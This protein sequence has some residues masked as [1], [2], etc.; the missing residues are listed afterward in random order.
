MGSLI[1]YSFNVILPMLIIGLYIKK[2]NREIIIKKYIKV[3]NFLILILVIMAILDKISYYEI[4]IKYWEKADES[5]LSALYNHRYLG[6]YRFYSFMGHPLYNAQLFLMFFV[7]NTCYNKYFKEILSSSKILVI[8]AL[9][10]ALTASKTGL[11]LLLVGIIFLVPKKNKFKY[12]LSLI[13]LGI[14]ILLS[15]VFN[16]TIER[17]LTTSLT[18]GRADIWELYKSMDIYPIKFL[19]GYGIDIITRIDEIILWG[20]AAFEYPIRGFAIQ[21]GV[22]FTIITYL[23]IG[24]YPVLCFIKNKNIYI[25]FGFLIIFLDVNTYNT[26]IHGRDYMI[27]YGLFVA[28]MNNISIH[29]REAIIN[30]EEK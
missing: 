23:I 6:Q 30:L 20:G 2:E 13:F 10:I 14:I 16:D 8:S 25:L 24:V 27:I 1:Y 28:I 12:Y 22:L 5:M 11:I 26:L 4:A 7:A 19:T 18:T 3:L 21:N 15:G 17:L 29:N 9:G